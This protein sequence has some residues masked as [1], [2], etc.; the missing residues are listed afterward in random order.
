M[1]FALPDLQAR[2]YEQA[3]G[4]LHIHARALVNSFHITIRTPPEILCTISSHLTEQDL[5]SASQVC[6]HWRE[7]LI[8]SACLWSRISCNNG[9]RRVITN[10][11]RCGSLPIQLR[12]EPPFPG[13]V[14]EDILLH[15]NRITSLTVNHVPRQ[16]SQL[17]QLFAFSRPSVERL[18]LYTGDHGGIP[19]LRTVREIWQDFPL[20]RE[21]LV[22]I[23]PVPIDRIAAPNLVHLALEHT[24]RQ[25]NVTPRTIL[26]MLRGCPLLETLLL[27]C[28]GDK[29]PATIHGI[30]SVHLPHLRSIELGP[31]EVYSGLVA[32]LNF[33]PDVAVGFQSIY[34]GELCGQVSDL[35]LASVQQVLKRISIRSIT[36]ATSVVNGESLIR[37][38]GH[39]GSLEISALCPLNGLRPMDFLFGLEGVLF[40]HS[41]N[42]ENVTEIHIADCRFDTT[43]R[44]LGHVSAAMPNI[45]TISFFRCGGPDP[46]ALLT[47]EDTPSLPF[48]HLERV[49]VLGHESGLEEMA[50]SRII[51]G[52]PLQT[53]VLGRDPGGFDYGH[54]EDYT[55]LGGLVGDLRVGCP[56]E[57]LKWRSGKEIVDV[58]SAAGA[59]SLVS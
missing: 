59:P 47:A 43:S 20:L 50:R 26:S 27:N 49:M 31:Y 40:S 41:P 55:V 42:I 36:F 7:A 53:L 45:N 14:L 5:F 37:F 58:W 51:L 32:R 18:L 46:F 30:S 9:P 52:V 57:I 1:S 15:G 54:L 22:V 44:G 21:L 38:E 11:K 8:S 56:V 35:T 33:S 10:F 29:Y 39:R 4:R 17:N 24:G 2:A 23:H 13:A 34:P 25:Q 48:P 12:L 19:E 6:R 28:T 16:I 3:I